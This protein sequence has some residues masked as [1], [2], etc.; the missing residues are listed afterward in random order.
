[1]SPPC[2]LTLQLT[3]PNLSNGHGGFQKKIPGMYGA[4]LGM[5]APSHLLCSVSQSSH[6]GRGEETPDCDG[7]SCKSHCKDCGNPESYHTPHA[8]AARS[9]HTILRGA[10]SLSNPKGISD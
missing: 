4:L 2:G 9:C 3:S 8:E 7:R 10:Q 5:T 1:M 6:A